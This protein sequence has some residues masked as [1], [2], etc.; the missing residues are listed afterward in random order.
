MNTDENKL[1]EEAQQLSYKLWETNGVPKIK[2]LVTDALFSAY[3]RG[4]KHLPDA[5]ERKN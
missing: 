1:K 4:R 5:K 3:N 2:K